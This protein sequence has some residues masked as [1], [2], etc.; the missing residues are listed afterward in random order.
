[1][2]RRARRA[3]P[4]SA[5][6]RNHVDQ[7]VQIDFVF[8]RIPCNVPQLKN[9]ETGF[10][11]Y[12][13]ELEV[14][15]PVLPHTAKTSIMT[16]KV[17]C[18]RLSHAETAEL[19]SNQVQ[20]LI[21]RAQSVV[22]R[23]SAYMRCA[24]TLGNPTRSTVLLKPGKDTAIVIQ[25]SCVHCKKC[26]ASWSSFAGH[27]CPFLFPPVPSLSASLSNGVSAPETQAMTTCTP[28]TG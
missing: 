24:H 28:A 2:L 8:V 6:F 1:M 26:F 15:C 13:I 18:Q 19:F 25:I 4:Q 9:P 27:A 7:A 22:L 3:G 12:P 23:S 10:R 5:V 16:A 21:P 14:P 11:H 20:Q 17:A